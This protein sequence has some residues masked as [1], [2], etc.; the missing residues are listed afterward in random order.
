[1]LLIHGNE[2]CQDIART[3]AGL[4]A[5]E[6]CTSV[7]KNGVGSEGSCVNSILQLYLEGVEMQL[8]DLVALLVEDGLEHEQ[9]TPPPRSLLF[10]T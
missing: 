3:M 7:G 6:I 4:T 2:N 10:S 8:R 9:G 1:M 5:L